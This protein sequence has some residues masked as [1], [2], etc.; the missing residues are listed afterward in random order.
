MARIGVS[1]AARMVGRDVSTLHR[2]MKAGRL[3]YT[4]D[5]SGRRRLDPAELGRLFEISPMRG[6]GATQSMDVPQDDAVQVVA[7]L[8][9]AV[10]SRDAM[11]G[12]LQRRL[13]A[14]EAER[15][16]LSERL[17]GLLTNNRSDEKSDKPWPR[18]VLSW[19]KKQHI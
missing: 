3:S 17:Q 10:Q 5:S 9:E 12:D 6:N 15:R 13:D 4:T 16:Q 8:R 1:E 2:M 19:L 18:R 14:S 11:L 7:L